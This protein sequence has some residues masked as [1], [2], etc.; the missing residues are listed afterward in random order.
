MPELLEVVLEDVLSSEIC[1]LFNS[2]MDEG[3][4]ITKIQCSEPLNFSSNH[5][6]LEDEIRSFINLSDDASLIVKLNSLNIAG[7]TIPQ[8][9]LRFL[10]YDGKYDIDFTFDEADLIGLNTKEL[11]EG[12]YTHISDITKQYQISDFFGGIEPA[13]DEDTRY[14]SSNG[15]GP[16]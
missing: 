3:G 11:M 10:K 2:L 7:Y 16:L 8:V 9:L 6:I 14:F 5:C 12:M 13:S 15:C 4:E 1:N